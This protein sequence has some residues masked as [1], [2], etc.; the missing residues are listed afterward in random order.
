M[1]FQMSHNE[2]L[3]EQIFRLYAILRRGPGL[4][5]EGEK[6]GRPSAQNRILLMLGESDGISQRDM[7]T[8]L[9]LRPQSVS[10]TLSK[11]VAAGLVERR[12]S[13]RDKRIFNIFLTDEGRDRVTELIENRP[14][15]AAEFL[16]PLTDEEKDRLAELLG[17]LVGF[18]GPE[19]D[20]GPEPDEFED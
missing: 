2:R 8:L 9:R 10:E 17:K 3:M 16:A 7:T 18:G 4:G 19:I 15:F 12:Q 6:G 11:L 13:A 5:G 20:L 1:D 14:D